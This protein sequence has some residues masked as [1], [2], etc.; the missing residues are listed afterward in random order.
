MKIVAVVMAV[1][2]A[3][4]SSSETP[5][6]AGYDAPM[7]DAPSGCQAATDCS[8]DNPCTTDSCDTRL[9]AQRA[10]RTAAE[11][12]DQRAGAQAQ[13]RAVARW[14][15]ELDRRR[16]DQLGARVRAERGRER[17]FGRRRERAAVRVGRAQRE[18]ADQ[19]GGDRGSREGERPAATGG[20]GV[21]EPGLELR[22]DLGALD[23]VERVVDRHRG[24]QEI[25]VAH[26][27]LLSSA[28]AIS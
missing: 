17:G 10:I 7:I 14:A 20:G 16:A 22:P 27:G 8:D 11:L 26:D 4:A 1:L 21:V 25:L 24:A 13:R 2:C 6:D 5:K 12:G 3:C 19:A 28:R 9:D 15:D 23:V 18:P